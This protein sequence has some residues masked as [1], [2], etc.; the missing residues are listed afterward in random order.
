MSKKISNVLIIGAGVAGQMVAKELTRSVVYK[1][2]VIGYLDDDIKKIGQT[3]HRFRVLDKIGNIKKIIKDKKIEEVIIAVPSQSQ[4]V[5][6]KVDDLLGSTDIKIRILPALA[7]VILGK[8]NLSFL[9]DVEPSDLLGRPLVQSDQKKIVESTKGMTFLI[10]GAAGS[11]GSEIVYQL[12][13]TNAKKIACLDSWEEGCFKLVEKYKGQSKPEIEVYVGNVRD[14]DRVDEVFRKV[15]PDVVFHAAAYKHVPLMEENKTEAD[16]TN[17]GGTENCLN[18]SVKYAVSGFVLIST[19]KAVNPSSHMGTTKRKAE[20][21]VMRQAKLAKKGKF[22]SVRF[23]NV[24]NSSGS[25]VPTFVSQVKNGGPVTITDKNMTR[26]FMTIPEAV[27]LV[28]QSWILGENGRIYVLDMGEPVKIIS[29]AEEIIRHFGLEPGKD[30]MIKEIGV[31][32]GEKL[33]EELSYKKEK[34]HTTSNPKIF[35]AE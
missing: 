14:K 19:D 18:A 35:I 29:L 26:F 8:V 31:R 25:V 32:P 34:L 1:S 13:L 21:M 24:L 9:K 7:P 3:Y 28:L 4:L 15:K 27:S 2:K 6:K 22:L 30:I 16:K 20:L 11:I 17:V 12:S 10:T 23:G 33:Y 5:A